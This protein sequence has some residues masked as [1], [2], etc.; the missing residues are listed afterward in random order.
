MGIVGED[1]REGL[2]GDEGRSRDLKRHRVPWMSA[3]KRSKFW[4][5]FLDPISRP[6]LRFLS[7]SY[8]S[9]STIAPVLSY[10]SLNRQSFL[11]TRSLTPP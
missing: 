9:N 4:K 8:L 1:P 11:A 5:S 10:A 2:S 6:N 7:L 3:G